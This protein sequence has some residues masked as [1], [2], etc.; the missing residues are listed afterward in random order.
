MLLKIVK[1]CSE[2]SIWEFEWKFHY[3]L[4]GSWFTD[5]WYWYSSWCPWG[6]RDTWGKLCLIW[7][8]QSSS[9]SLY[10]KLGTHSHSGPATLECGWIKWAYSLR[11]NT[12]CLSFGSVAWNL[13]WRKIPIF[14]A[15]M[16]SIMCGVKH[17]AQNDN[18]YQTGIGEYLRSSP[19]HLPRPL[20]VPSY[21]L[22]NLTD[23]I[24]YAF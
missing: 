21:T 6:S 9:Y 8:T 13:S 17:L 16:K 1:T 14:S 18:G 23:K 12:D 20:C 15:D 19:S 4:C 2:V 11:H 3:R 10:R 5:R 7:W 22:H 24:S